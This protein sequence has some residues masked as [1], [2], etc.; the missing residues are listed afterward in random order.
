MAS[1]AAIRREVIYS[2]RVQGVGFRWNARHIAR[3][4]DVTGYVRNLDDGRVQLV[5]E[6]EPE[7]LD[8]LLDRIAQS[9][10]GNIAQQLVNT[11]PATGQFIGFEIAP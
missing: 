8:L 3:D 2:G 10:R 5:A 6:G 9:M 1:P 7:L 4:F 11:S